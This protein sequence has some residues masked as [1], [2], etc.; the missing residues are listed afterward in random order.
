MSIRTY[1]CEN[2]HILKSQSA[3][4]QA[5]LNDVESNKICGSCRSTISEIETN[6]R[7][8]GELTCSKHL[9]ALK[10]NFGL[11]TSATE[12]ELSKFTSEYYSGHWEP[13][14]LY[15]G[16]A[17][18]SLI[19]S[20]A[21]HFKLNINR[22]KIKSLSKIEN[23]HNAILENAK[24]MLSE[25]K[26]DEATKQKIVTHTKALTSA[27]HDIQT[28]L[29]RLIQ[30]HDDIEYGAQD[31]SYAL[32]QIETHLGKAVG[33]TAY[34]KFCND[35][36]LPCRDVMKKRDAAAHPNREGKRKTVRKKDVLATHFVLCE[37]IKKLLG[38]IK[39]V[40]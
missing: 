9:I 37:V 40:H 10:T 39:S 15:V 24:S 26:L 5:N 22:P 29:E 6:V 12:R 28:E 20:L 8:L 18:E 13:A 38:T 33:Q 7:R 27:S 35:I 3:F 17:T 19:F 23:A 1:R 32:K 16:R 4:L 31:F 21:R 11:D 14:L 36:S 25:M 34:K 2:C 30:K